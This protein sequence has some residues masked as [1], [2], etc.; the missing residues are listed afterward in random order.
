MKL[1]SVLFAL[2]LMLEACSSSGSSTTVSS[3]GAALPKCAYDQVWR[4]GTVSVPFDRA[5]PSAGTIKIAFF[6]QSHTGT[7]KPPLEP[8]F[9]SPGGPGASIWASHDFVPIPMW[10][11]DH[12]T[13]LIEPRGVGRSGPIACQGLQNGVS[14]FADLRTA[15]ADCGHQLGPTADRYGT[16]DVALDIEDVR[17]ALGVA[18]F[19]FY[20]ASYG[21]IAEQAYVTRFPARVHALVLD[22]AF[23]AIDPAQSY[24]LGVGYPA[25]WIRVLK[26]LCQRAP[27]CASANPQ[28]QDLID[29]LVRRV[30]SS[31]IRGSVA[32]AA[33]PTVVDEAAVEGLLLNFGP[34]SAQLHAKDLL[35]AAAALKG[36]DPG[37]ILQLVNQWP[38]L[39][40]SSTDPGTF[41]NGDNAAASCNDQAFPWDRADS[42]ALRE[43]KLTAAYAALPG[44]TFDPFTTAGW[45]AGNIITTDSCITWPSPNRFEPVI[46]AGAKFPS[47]PTLIVSG[48]ED[49]QAPEEISRA[50]Q[51]EFPGATFMIVAGAGHNA[52]APPGYWGTSC[53]GSQVAKFFDTLRVDPAACA[54]FSG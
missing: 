23:P 47:L 49:T 8:I 14:T 44:D 13:V 41:S 43:Q 40:M 22:S 3:L 9:V 27:D 21:T 46:P 50:L 2:A 48:D 39:A 19:D 38:I 11:A 54:T 37:P 34:T 15:T 28:P 26:L 36:G 30:A 29:S 10:Q 5:N 33:G 31:P 32:G 51:A 7:R 18:A 53:G 4:C 24:A 42:V 20:A 16:G 6:I 17:K 45:A 1:A 35:D 25:A 52:A 12:D